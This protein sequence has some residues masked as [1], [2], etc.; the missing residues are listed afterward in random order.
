MS[1]DFLPQFNH[2]T[3]EQ[4]LRRRANIDAQQATLRVS[5]HAAE[6]RQRAEQEAADK[7]RIKEAKKIVEARKQQRTNC[8]G[9]RKSNQQPDQE[10]LTAKLSRLNDLNPEAL[11]GEA[12]TMAILHIFRGAF[13]TEYFVQQ[14]AFTDALNLDEQK[15]LRIQANAATDDNV[16][17]AYAPL[18]NIDGS[19]KIDEHGN[20]EFPACYPVD[21]AGN[22]DYHQ[23]P[24]TNGTA[25]RAAQRA[26]GFVPI[27]NLNEAIEIQLLKFMKDMSGAQGFT[28][29]QLN[30]LNIYAEEQKNSGPRSERE[31]AWENQG[32]NAR[33]QAQQHATAAARTVRRPGG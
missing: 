4:A 13:L 3:E 31:M 16:R 12:L 17:V 26:N 29:E 20:L 1:L 24:N 8:V 6:D 21:S 23:T 19:Y 28:S 9:Y 10:S 33:M 27:E 30:K 14:F 11:L 2:E 32:V 5:N 22:I 25:S 15:R 18:R 7:R